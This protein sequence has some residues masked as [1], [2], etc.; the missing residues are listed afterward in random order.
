M[1][2]QASA[3]RRLSPPE[4]LGRG[5]VGARDADVAEDLVDPMELIPAAEPLDLRGHLRLLG[6]ERSL[7]PFTMAEPR[8]DRLVTRLRRG[9]GAEPL[10]D[11]LAARFRRIERR[12]LREIR[13][14]RAAPL[15]D[16]ARVRLVEPGED[17]G[18]RALA[19][20]IGS[21]E[22]YVFSTVDGKGDAIE[23]APLTKRLC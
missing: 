18:E 2:R 8:R 11:Q 20:P 23:D 14:L 19:A 9:P 3:T 1:S 10:D 16:R 6:E 21:D 17:T 12:L 5:R 22:P 13:D 15:R 4:K 7:I